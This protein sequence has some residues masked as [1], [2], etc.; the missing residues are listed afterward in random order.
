M[1]M[2]RRAKWHPPPPPT[3]RILHLPRR[4][5]RKQPTKTVAGKSIFGG[6]P[7]VRGP[8]EGKLECLFDQE[9]WFS[10]GAPPPIVFLN[11]SGGGGSRRLVE[12]TGD[13]EEVEQR[14]TS[15]GGGI[16]EEDKWRFQAEILRAECKFLRMERGIAVKKLERERAFME[17]T[18]KSAV[19]TLISGKRKICEGK[20]VNE[21]LE[22]EIEDLAKMLVELQRSSRLR[23]FELGNC[24]NFDKQAS[25]L[26]KKLKNG[27][28]SERK[29][30]KET[31][32]MEDPSLYMLDAEDGIPGDLASD[33]KCHKF[34]DVEILRSKMEGLSNGKLLK[35]ME[36]GYGSV[37]AAT[38]N[39]CG[40]SS[41]STSRQYDLSDLP[42]S[43]PRLSLQETKSGELTT[44]AGHC[45]AIIRRI[46]EQVR[47][48]TE[49]W[50][51]MQEMLGQVKE[52]MEE[53]QASRDF[54]EDR[55]LHSDEKIHSLH[56]SVEEWKQKALSH[57]MKANELQ[58]QVI[59]LQEGLERLMIQRGSEMKKSKELPPLS[60]EAT[61]PN[62]KEKRVLTC[63]VKENNRTSD[64]S[65]RRKDVVTGGKK[66]LHR[67]SSRPVSPSRLP[68][69]D[70]GNLSPLLRQD[71]KRSVF[72][73]P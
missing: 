13:E 44:C 65:S 17:T 50:S 1:T 45:K 55:A 37:V 30:V 21:V 29:C 42:S 46:V 52:E 26:Q 67:G 56:S 48:E 24:S 33:H 40:A 27:S 38:A 39:C 62:E 54:W 41:A 23:D 66:A 69:R 47:A 10:Y 60:W 31:Q 6:D 12:E 58:K 63:R 61:L 68:F 9:Q 35:K 53:L 11:S 59:M 25:L 49:Q 14:E 73:F 70:V 5:C 71:S 57:E 20:S 32:E 36:E 22:E 43:A 64:D 72:P 2:A 16:S 34:A 3:P 8:P 4:S 28:A 7:V 18:L 51:Q 15:G 19:H